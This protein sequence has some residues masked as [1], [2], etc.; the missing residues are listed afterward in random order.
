MLYLEVDEGFSNPQVILIP[1]RNPSE[2]FKP[3]QEYQDNAFASAGLHVP[4]A[5][6]SASGN[7]TSA[8]ALTISDGSRREEQQRMGPILRASDLEL[9][10]KTAATLNR[11]T[12]TT[13]PESGY[14]VSYHVLP[15]TPQERAATVAEAEAQYA[16]GLISK[17]ALYQAYHP[18]TDSQGALQ[19]LVRA[20]QEEQQLA[21]LLP[22]PPP[23]PSDPDPTTTPEEGEE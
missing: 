12:G 18:G 5:T 20:Q 23:T 9:L 21:A 22:K 7:P 3:V 17:V 19:A 8:A 2:I 6:R 15:A 13:Y 11:V 16:Q 4:D 1:G 14:S 10:G